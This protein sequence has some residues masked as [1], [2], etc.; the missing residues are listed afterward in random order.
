MSLSIG[1]SDPLNRTCLAALR[2]LARRFE[3]AWVSDHLLDRGG[4]PQST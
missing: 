3:A 4:P 1:S 2:A